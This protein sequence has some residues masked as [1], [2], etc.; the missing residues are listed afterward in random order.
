[1]QAAIAAVHAEAGTSLVTD[2]RQIA[3]L[4]SELATIN[5]SPVVELNRAVAIGMHAGLQQGLDLVAQL[6]ESLAQYH[7]FHAARADLLRRL[8]RKDAAR[9][10]YCR[11]LALTTNAMERA[12]MQQRIRSL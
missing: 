3:A 10:A 7:L 2:W 12:Y 8:D 5:P 1:L 4:Y 11:A 9:E 6:A